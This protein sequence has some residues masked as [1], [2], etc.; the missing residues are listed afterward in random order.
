[1]IELS[2]ARSLR[3]VATE[4]REQRSF[5][6]PRCRRLFTGSTRQFLA[7]SGEPESALHQNLRAEAFFFAQN[8]EQQMLRAYMLYAEALRLFGGHVQNA[9][10]LGA[11]R[12][13]HRRRDSLANRDSRF[14][15]LAN[16]FDRTLLPQKTVR[17]SLVLAHQAEQQV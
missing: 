3:Q 8:S 13:L 9:L 10:A 5:F 16:R 11:E 1:R 4:F 6:R 7:Q 17:Q 12:N 15:F 2:L 14:Y